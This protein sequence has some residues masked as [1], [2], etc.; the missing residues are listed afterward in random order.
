M[1]RQQVPSMQRLHMGEKGWGVVAEQDI[2]PGTFVMEYMG[3]MMAL[4]PAT[5]PC[6]S[7][8]HEASSLP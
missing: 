2:Q 4:L 6:C 3:T 8:G 7:S 1:Q 5:L